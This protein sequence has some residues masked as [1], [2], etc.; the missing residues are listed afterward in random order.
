[1][2]APR[3]VVVTVHSTLACR[4]VLDAGEEFA[5]LFGVPVHGRLIEDRTASEICDLPAAFLPRNLPQRAS[6]HPRRTMAAALAREA[7]ALKAE[8]A[9]IADLPPPDISGP[10]D[11]VAPD[12]LVVLSADLSEPSL[13]AAVRSAAMHCPPAGAVLV[14]PERRPSRRGAVLVLAASPSDRAHGVGSRIA[15]SLGADTIRVTGADGRPQAAGQI[16]LPAGVRLSSALIHADAVRLI[17]LGEG[18][19]EWLELGQADSPVHRFRTTMLILGPGG[20]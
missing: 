2:I 5:R 9:R 13:R 19:H 20:G 14:V 10:E 12:D 3:R 4:T 8:I 15:A 6:V 18:M 11:V 17:V 16:K 1:M 7:R